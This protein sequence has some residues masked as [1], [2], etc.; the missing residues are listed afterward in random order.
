MAE[1]E[2]VVP[3]VPIQVIVYIV[4]TIGAIVSVPLIDLLP[5]HPFDALQETTFCEFHDKTAVCP[6]YIVDG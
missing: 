6:L 2:T 3:F 1:S 5:L 4:V